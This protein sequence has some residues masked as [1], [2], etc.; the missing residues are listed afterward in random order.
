MPYIEQS[1]DKRSGSTV[2]RIENVPERFAIVVV[3]SKRI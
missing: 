2:A 1:S 3:I